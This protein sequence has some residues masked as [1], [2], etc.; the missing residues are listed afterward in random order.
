MGKEGSPGFWPLNLALSGFSK[1]L[2]VWTQCASADSVCLCPV[3]TVFAC[4]KRLLSR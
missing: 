4:L 2:T 1:R 3:G